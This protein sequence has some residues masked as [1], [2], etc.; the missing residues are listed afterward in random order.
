MDPSEIPRVTLDTTEE[1]HTGSAGVS[2]GP[3]PLKQLHGSSPVP[4]PADEQ[5]PTRPVHLSPRPAVSSP[6]S[7]ATGR[8]IASVHGPPPSRVANPLVSNLSLLGGVEPAFVF[9]IDLLAL[10]PQVL[11]HMVAEAV[12]LHGHAPPSPSTSPVLCVGY[13][14]A[15]SRKCFAPCSRSSKNNTLCALGHGNAHGHQRSRSDG[16]V[17]LSAVRWV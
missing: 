8:D 14:V 15:A 3:L 12:L 9:D 2:R 4:S 11:E 16:D 1:A 7:P 6:L 10:Y 13:P 5:S 17:L